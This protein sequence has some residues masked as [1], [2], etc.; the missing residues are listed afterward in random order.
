MKKK[1]DFEKSR[2]KWRTSEKKNNVHNKWFVISL[3]THGNVNRDFE[4]TRVLRCS[5]SILLERKGFG[6]FDSSI[7]LR[8][9]SSPSADR[10]S[11]I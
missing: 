1:D 11:K 3:Y 9:H 4:I 6:I 5:G 10:F 8:D 7:G 2:Q